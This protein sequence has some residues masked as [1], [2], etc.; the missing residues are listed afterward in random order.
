MVLLL[1]WVINMV[2]DYKLIGQRIKTC[3][4]EK[5][6][7]QENVAE[8][9]DISFSYVSRVERAAVKISL[10]TLVKIATFLKTTPT[11]LIDG[12]VKISENY[13]QGEL[14]EAI[15]GFDSDKMKL[16]LEIA[17]SI[18]KFTLQPPNEN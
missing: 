14:A 11:Y 1:K 6:Y 17:Q 15:S 9:L 2:I 13:L 16:L 5:G 3:R 12:T 10:E 18:N 8:H 7:T 4:I